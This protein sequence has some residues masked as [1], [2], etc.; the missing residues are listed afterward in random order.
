MPSPK[1]ELRLLVASDL[2]LPKNHQDATKELLE[3]IRT[4]HPDMVVLNGDIIDG[5]S[6][7]HFL[8]KPNAPSFQQEL[9]AASQ[10]FKEFRSAVGRGR[11]E[12][13]LGNHC[14]RLRKLQWANPGLY[15]LRCLEFHNLLNIPE[16]RV[17]PFGDVVY[18]G[19]TGEERQVAVYHGDKRLTHTDKVARDRLTQTKAQVVI[20]GHTHRMKVVTVE[21]RL[22]KGTSVECGCLYDLLKVE[23]AKPA[24]LWDLGW[25][26]VTM[27]PGRHPRVTPVYL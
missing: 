6:I 21:D 5:E 23:Y 15:G 14:D 4:S 3:R 10:F 24:P 12:Y 2:H 1:G 26:E 9:D 27:A 25:V 13:T 16:A 22:G 8:T 18:F 7:S 19:P 17:H 20:V 11:W